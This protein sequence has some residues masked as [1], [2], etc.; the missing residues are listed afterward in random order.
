MATNQYVVAWRRASRD[1]APSDWLQKIG[2]IDGV[3]VVGATEHRAQVTAD[4]AGLARIQRDFGPEMLIEPV[5]VHH[6]ASG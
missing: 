6:P 4:E 3:S 5:I 1:H 2:A